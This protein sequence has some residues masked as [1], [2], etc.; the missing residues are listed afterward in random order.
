MSA[1]TIRTIAIKAEGDLGV[2]PQVSLL[3]QSCVKM[4]SEHGR[5]T[6]DFYFQDLH[7]TYSYAEHKVVHKGGRK[8]AKKLTEVKHDGSGERHQDA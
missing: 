7:V 6:G 4:N 1:K 3:I 5:E 2:V 8:P